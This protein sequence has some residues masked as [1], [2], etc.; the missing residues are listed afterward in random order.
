MTSTA[1]VTT[2]QRITDANWSRPD[3]RTISAGIRG[4]G[5]STILAGA[6]G[7]FGLAIGP[8][9]AGLV[10]ATGTAS[11]IVAYPIAAILLFAAVQPAFA[12]LLTLMPVPVMA[13]GLLFPAAFIMIGGLQIIASRVLDARRTL[14][15]GI[16]ILAFLLVAL[17]PHT[18]A[19][20]PQWL[21]PIV[22]SPLVFATIVA[23]TLNLLFRIGIKRSAD[24]K[25]ETPAFQFEEVETFVER[26]GGSWGARRELIM[27]VKLALQQAVESAIELWD[28]KDPIILRLT[29]DELDIEAKVIYAGEPLM[30]ADAA[31]SMDQVDDA[32]WHLR[33]AGFLLKRQADK[34]VSSVRD[35]DCVLTMRFRQ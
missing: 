31:P 32:D 4:D 21:Q 16:G 1:I 24:L 22:N 15:I 17:F 26:I 33:L 35:G 12:N 11:R 8:A 28:K 3:M 23:L 18:F 2:Y 13:A 27:R 10:A 5:L 7:T 20:A 25:I 14:L 19:G 9:N 29:Y 6:F 34:I 30:V